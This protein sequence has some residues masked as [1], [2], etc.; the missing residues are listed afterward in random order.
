MGK[1]T[2]IRR[3]ERKLLEIYEWLHILN[4][5]LIA[6]EFL[7]GSL[8]FLSHETQHVGVWLFVLGSGQ[9]LVGPVIR[10]ANKLHVR[11]L[12]SARLNW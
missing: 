5:G 10:A 8:M 3:H 6:L 7:I 2:D 11:R 4:D 1:R 12:R 9:M